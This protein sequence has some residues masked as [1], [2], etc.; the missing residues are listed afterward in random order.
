[1]IGNTQERNNQD[2][3]DTSPNNY[4]SPVQYLV[5]SIPLK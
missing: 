4:A 3:Y 2:I 5:L 1:M